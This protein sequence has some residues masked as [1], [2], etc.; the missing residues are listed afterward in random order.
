MFI[1]KE[2]D[3][4]MA[5]R[6]NAYAFMFVTSITLLLIAP[7]SAYAAKTVSGMDIDPIYHTWENFFNF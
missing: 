1:Y 2:W 5:N 7:F 4:V 3:S 6:S